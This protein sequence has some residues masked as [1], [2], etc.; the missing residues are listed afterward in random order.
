M[1]LADDLRSIRC[2]DV[3]DAD[4]TRDAVQYDASI[5]AARPEVV[6]A[7]T[8]SD[9]IGAL[10]RYAA[11][12]SGVSIVARGAGTDMSGG[13]IG[14]SVI[15]DMTRHL[16]RLLDVN[17]D[18][19]VRGQQGS[20]TVQPGMYYRDFER[21]TLARGLQYPV[22]PASRDLCTV[23]GM[24]ANN[25]AGERSL[26][27][28]QAV[29]WVRSCRAILADG[30]EYLFEPLDFGGVQLKMSRI[31]F[32]GDLYRALWKLVTE[33][34]E[35]LERY[36][37]KVS[38]NASGYNLWRVWDGTTFDL[39]KLMVG[40]Q[41]TL[42]VVTR[43]TL[44]LIRPPLHRRMVVVFLR[45]LP[46]V[47]SVVDDLLQFQPESLE[48]FDDKTLSFTVRFL[49]DFVRLM[50]ASNIIALGLQ[51]LPEA[52]MTVTGGLPKLVLM[53]EFSGD[54]EQEVTKRAEAALGALKRRHL[55]ARLTEGPEESHKYWTI[56]RQSFN[57][58][59]HHTTGKRTV[60]FIDDIIVPVERMSEFLP[61]LYT[62]LEPYRLTLTVAGHAGNGNFHI[63][64]LMDLAD[65]NTKK[66]IV[67][68]SEKVYDL[69]LDHGGSITA[70]HNDGLIRGPWVR[71]QFGPKMYDLFRQVKQ[72]FD[73]K[74]I[75]NPG[76]KIDVDREWALAHI[77]TN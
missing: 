41:G 28:G 38:K 63:I 55:K 23:G 13:A 45:D 61:K 44:G 33:Q 19:A 75:F 20:A 21:A 39:T 35:F 70:E 76:K 4:A 53:A 66:T 7:P 73:P 43:V 77:R 3:D 17:R 22:Y 62:L 60:P 27:Y 51:F 14:E 40:S 32:E 11:A 26:R 72:L 58:L 64:P 42:G 6:V 59:R 34:R 37:P 67:E 36:Q 16:N 29:D 49:P 56:R 24:V 8:S 47:A 48:S 69:V 18:E 71:K 1:G 54:D 30:N 9:E 68:L 46:Y 2:G 25:S 50:G 5:F 74:G 15:L 31:G 52:W 10:V 65:P 12:H 57:V